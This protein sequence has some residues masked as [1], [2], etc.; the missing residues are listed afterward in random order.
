MYFHTYITFREFSH[1]RAKPTDDHPK[2]F[3]KRTID[4]G[5]VVKFYLP[6]GTNGAY[7]G[8]YSIFKN[9]QEFVLNRNAK[10]EA[11]WKSKNEMEV[12]VYA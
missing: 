11:V 4:D 6:K 5:V 3:A 2:Q 1:H 10:Y 12:Y 7:I 9:E 8:D